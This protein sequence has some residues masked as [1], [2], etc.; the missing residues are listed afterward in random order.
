MRAYG[1]TNLN[2]YAVLLIILDIA[3]FGAISF[4]R[5]QKNVWIIFLIL[6]VVAIFLGGNSANPDYA[7]YQ[8]TYLHG[9]VHKIEII[10]T[11]LIDIGNYLG[12]SFQVF[13]LELYCIALLLLYIAVSRVEKKTT[14][15]WV[16]YIVFPMMLDGTQTRNFLAMV[17]VLNAVA[18]LVDRNKGNIIKFCVLIA[19]ATGFQAL[20]LLFI[21]LLLIPYV[22]NSKIL[23]RII[24]T[25]IV[26]SIILALNRSALSSVINSISLLYGDVDSRITKYGVIQTRYG[27]LLSWMIHMIIFGLSAYIRK[28]IHAEEGRDENRVKLIEFAY[29][30]SIISFLY[31]PFY[32]LVST[33]DRIYRTVLVFEYALWTAAL[34]N[35]DVSIHGKKFVIRLDYALI[36]IAIIAF[37]IGLFTANINS[38]Y[39]ETIV[40]TF[41]HDNWIL[42]QLF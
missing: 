3:I 25:V 30:L 28:K 1:R 7:T 21:L 4:K 12:F 31:F 6:V 26:F 29:W 20:S 19:F 37:S 18:F 11:L 14:F 35:S 40:Q 13:R 39:H 32:V 27:F 33:F 22:E 24:I 34:Q 36:S 15:F 16:L 9:R 17:I 10:Y 8:Y 23:R 42:Q 38:L 2:L 41:F 5:K